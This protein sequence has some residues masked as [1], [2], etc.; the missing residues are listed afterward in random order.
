MSHRGDLTERL[1]RIP[2]LL[3]ERP[4]SQQELAQEFNVDG[5]TIRR[6]LN[7]L[8]RF[9]YITDER[10]GRQVFYRF[11]DGYQ[12]RPPNFM[13]AE[14][15]MLLL[16]Q[17]SIAATGLASFGTPFAGYGRALLAKVR[18]TLPKGL[19]D[20][21][22][23]LASVF[24]TAAVPAKDY[25]PHAG[26][27]EKLTKAAVTSRRV[28]MRYHTLHSGDVKDREFDPYSVYFD[29]DGA[30][31]KVIGLDY[32]SGEIKPFSIDHI[33]ALS[34]TGE[35]FARPPGFNLQEFLTKYCFNGIHG[36]PITVRLRAYGVTARIFAERQYHP[37]QREVEPIARTADGEEAVTIEMTV[38]RGRGLVRFILSWGPE[39]EVIDPPELRKEVAEAHRQALARYDRSG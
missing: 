34:E 6:N 19:R 36:Q 31:L 35:T 12:Y 18:S 5:I 1:V 4:R 17:Q 16:A 38:A 32:D 22:D 9:Y 23:A 21:L 37:S 24:G 26:T 39:L 3:A 28:V 13:P 30:T 25:R 27:I 10:R 20:Y 14:L 2:L 15:A 8:S 11:G 7:E 29:P 33:R